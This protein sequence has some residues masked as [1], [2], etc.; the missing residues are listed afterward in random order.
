MCRNREVLCCSDINASNEET[1]HSISYQMLMLRT[2]QELS[3][4]CL[5]EREVRWA[6][7]NTVICSSLPSILAIGQ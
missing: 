1:K 5:K 6:M 2:H 3:L 4:I 7:D